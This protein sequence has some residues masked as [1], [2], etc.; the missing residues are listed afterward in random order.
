[1]ILVNIAAD[2]F[3]LFIDNANLKLAMTKGDPEKEKN[4]EDMKRMMRDD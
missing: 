2:L 4:F 3:G 1:M